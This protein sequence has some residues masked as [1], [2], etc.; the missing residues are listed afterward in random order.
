MESKATG[1]GLVLEGGGLRGMFTCGVLDA[2]MDHGIEF[3]ALAGVSAGVLFGSNYKSGQR[4]R[5]LKYNLEYIDNAEY[6]S[7]KSLI[8]T[9]NYVNERFSYQMIPYF[10]YPFD[11]AAYKKNPMKLYAVC[12][13]IE[14]GVPIYKEIDDANGEGMSWMQAS[15]SMPV[16][17]KPVDIRG[18]KYLD[19][20]ITDSIPL[21]FMHD[22]GYGRNIVVLTQPADFRKKKAHVKL[23][24]KMFLRNYPSVASLMAERHK[25]YNAQLDYVHE[26]VRKGDTFLI[27]PNTKLDIG[28]LELDKDKIQDVY[29]EGMRMANS[30]MP[31]I[32]DFLDA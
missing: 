24:M 18:H 17:A 4:G 27:C 32:K 3:D 5:A 12:T 15:A 8:R 14:A 19:G 20:G 13:D 21:R 22:S 23:A 25:M 1:K 2:F 31:Q 26:S 7:M 29:Y 11:F 9:G 10:Y 6:M 16:F 30:L 28:R